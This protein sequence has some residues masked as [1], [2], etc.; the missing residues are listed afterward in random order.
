MITSLNPSA[1]Q[2]LNNLGQINQQMQQAETQLSTGLSVN[3][4]S[5]APEKISGIMQ[6][7]ASLSS[8]NQINTDIAQTNTEVNSGEQA[9]ES[10]VQLFDQV[11]TL[12]SE[13]NTST[14]TASSNAQL[15]QQV[16]TVLQEMVGLA[17]TQSGGRYIFSGDMDQVE[18]YSIDMTQNPPV[19]SSYQGS[20]STRVAQSPDGSTFP[21][22]LTA[23]TIF[24][25]SDPTTN[26]YAAMTNLATALNNNDSAGIQ[27]AVNGL[28]NVSGY[29]N[30]QLAF[31]GTTQQNV[32]QATNYGQTLATQLQTQLGNLEDA[33]SAAA[34]EQLTQAQTQDQ[35]ALQSEALLPRTSLFNFLG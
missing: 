7:Q 5:D 18:P 35:A 27:T 10:A 14:A 19:V 33:D 12:A 23:Q 21:V 31:Y 8:T 4:A 29:L 16:G 24:D 17:N 30:Q 13:G 1:E 32:Q 25:S 34:I 22:A 28:A 2:F 11:Q 26:V 6:A 15:G 3:Q 9:M 20:A